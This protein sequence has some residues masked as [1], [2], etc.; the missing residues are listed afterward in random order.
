MYE[1]DSEKESLEME[2]MRETLERGKKLR[3][4]ALGSSM[5]PTIR[6]GDIITLEPA[7]LGSIRLGDL[8]FFQNKGQFF[9]HRLIKKQQINGD[10]FFVTR[11]DNLPLPDLPFKPS[12][13]RGKAVMLERG[14]RTIKFD[15]LFNRYFNRLMAIISPL[16]YFFLRI[17]VK[18]FRIISRLSLYFSSKFSSISLFSRFKGV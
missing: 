12:Q 5:F 15:S 3:F 10:P 13:V 18:S 1:R 11:G 8:L 7:E 14:N 4:R 17:A 16:V 6:G 9:L 2:L